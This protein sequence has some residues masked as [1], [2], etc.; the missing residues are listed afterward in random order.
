MKQ[1][2]RSITTRFYDTLFIDILILF[3]NLPYSV[4]HSRL[5]AGL[6]D[7]SIP[8]S[9]LSASSSYSASVA[10]RL[11]RLR[12]E[13][14]G[15]AWCPQQVL[16]NTSTEWLQVSRG[17]SLSTISSIAYLHVCPRLTSGSPPG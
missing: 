5:C 13:A 2:R 12:G 3:E 15:G 10:P 11:A 7:G 14:G 16:T 9:A 6:E 17:A 4:L 1:N 8:D